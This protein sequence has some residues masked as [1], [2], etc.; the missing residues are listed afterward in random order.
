MQSIQPAQ[1]DE[2]IQHAISEHPGV[3]P[4]LLD[5]REAWEFETARVQADPDFELKHIPMGAVPARYLE[6]DRERP[7]A[8]LCHHG[9]RSARV[10][11]FLVQQGFSQV[12]NVHGGIDAWSHERDPG[13][14]LY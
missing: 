13:I 10:A 5:V 7:I 12:V 6:L 11:Y 3:K 8:C 1:F 9:V 4:V 14:P 2:W